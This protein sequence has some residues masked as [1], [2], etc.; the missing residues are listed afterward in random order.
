MTTTYI[1]DVSYPSYFQPALNP[2]TLRYVGMPYV[3]GG[4][5]SL[6]KFSY[7]DLGCGDATL[8]TYLALMYPEAI[9]YGVDF[10]S[11][12]IQSG[13]RRAA[14]LGL[15]NL[16]LLHS[17]FAELQTLGMQ[18][19]FDFIA[20][21]G[22]YSWVNKDMQRAI[23]EF[24]IQRLNPGGIFCVHYALAPGKTQI[25]PMWRFVREMGKGLIPEGNSVDQVQAGV[26]L[27]EQAKQLDASFFTDNPVAKRRF[28]SIYGDD[29]EYLAH[30]ALTDWQALYFSEVAAALLDGGLRYAG[31]AQPY[32]NIIE[33]MFRPEVAPYIRGVASPVAQETLKDYM[34]PRGARVDVYVKADKRPDEASEPQQVAGLWVRRLSQQPTPDPLVFASGARWELP[35]VAEAV[36]AYCAERSV[37]LDALCAAPALLATADAETIKNTIKMLIAGQQLMVVRG[38]ERPQTYDKR[39]ALLLEAHIPKMRTGY[40]ILPWLGQVYTLNY[41]QQR[42]MALALAGRL[43]RAVRDLDQDETLRRVH[44][45]NLPQHQRD[46]YTD[47]LAWHVERFAKTVVPDLD[48]LGFVWPE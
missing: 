13:R 47:W 27:L 3:S 30:E 8:L 7:C 15:S 19:R 38:D 10:N 12:H 48:A 1:S 5:P 45:A 9:F 25:A 20:C 35:P 43:E 17:D 34:L 2:A 26:Q 33:L 18:H 39:I 44:Q 46:Q 11:Q 16:I 22:A 31:Q 42:I 6:S 4:L 14:T 32:L 37:T 24:V 36:L 28:E 40:V 23:Q 21:F 29:I 41:P